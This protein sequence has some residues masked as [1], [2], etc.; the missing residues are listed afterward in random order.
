[1]FRRWFVFAGL[2]LWSGCSW[3]VAV[4]RA[5]DVAST[6]ATAMP[7]LTLATSAPAAMPVASRVAAMSTTLLPPQYGSSALK[8][9]APFYASTAVL[10]LLDVRST[11][12]VLSLGG[13]ESNPLIHG[14]VAH[15]ALFVGV[16]AVIA[17][18]S[19]YAA[20][21]MARHSKLGAIVTMVAITSVY[22]VVVSH[23]FAVARSMR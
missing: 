9:M 20:T 4:V 19:I 16:K 14:V 5:Q 17:A 2:I 22:A 15:P 3:G 1:M 10:Q 12:E 13:H 23:N 6:F 7:K 21:K 11:L 18:G 8:T